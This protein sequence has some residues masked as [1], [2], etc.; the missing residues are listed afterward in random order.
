[1]SGI[2]GLLLLA[3]SFFI[4]SEKMQRRIAVHAEWAWSGAKNLVAAAQP[5]TDWHNAVARRLRPITA[6]LY[7]WVWRKVVVA[8][9]GIVL[10][11]VALILFSPYWLFRIFRRRPWMK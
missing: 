10:G 7:R 9:L 1:L 6:W 5:K 2:V 3:W 11:V 4:W 8:V